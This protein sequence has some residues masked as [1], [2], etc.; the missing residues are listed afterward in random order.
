MSASGACAGFFSQLELVCARPSLLAM[1]PNHCPLQFNSSPTHQYLFRDICRYLHHFSVGHKLPELSHDSFPVT[2]KPIGANPALTLGWHIH[3]LSV[4]ASSAPFAQSLSVHFLISGLGNWYLVW[5][6][7]AA[8]ALIWRYEWWVALDE[9]SP[10]YSTPIP[11][12]ATYFIF[13]LDR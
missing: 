4:R 2:N 1:H 11:L 9:S 5:P 6:L 7:F 10:L 8:T 13:R 12:Q 3:P